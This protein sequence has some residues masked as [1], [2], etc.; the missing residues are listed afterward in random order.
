MHGARGGF[1]LGRMRGIEGGMEGHGLGKMFRFMVPVVAIALAKLGKAHGYQ[2]AQEA[3]RLSVA[4]T[5]MDQ[6]AVYRTLR[7]M[8]MMGFTYSEWDTSGTGPARRVYMLSEEGMVQLDSWMRRMERL[9]GQIGILLKAYGELERP[10]M[11][12][13]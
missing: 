6:A 5:E 9:S 12:A 10:D 3:S 1:G 11:P 4:D 8:D 2:I 13:K 7:R